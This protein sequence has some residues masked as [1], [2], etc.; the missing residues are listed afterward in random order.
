MRGFQTAGL[1]LGFAIALFAASPALAAPGGFGCLWPVNNL[2]ENARLSRYYF[3]NTER[4]Y[5]L[6]IY[7]NEPAP[8]PKGLFDNMGVSIG[9]GSPGPHKVAVC[10]VVPPHLESVRRR[11]YWREVKGHSIEIRQTEPGGF[12]DWLVLR[13]KT[14]KVAGAVTIE[15]HVFT[16]YSSY[17]G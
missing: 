6:R 12:N 11:I 9:V 15:F 2:Y 4:V 5:T 7:L 3:D 14:P 10:K 1:V 16:G 17:A 13:A 8:E